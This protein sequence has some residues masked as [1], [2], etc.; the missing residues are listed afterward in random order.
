M[1]WPL[2]AAAFLALL[3][4][5]IHGIVGDRIVRRIQEDSLPGNPFD[6]IPTKVLIRVTWHFVTIAFFVLGIALATSGVAPRGQHARGVAYVAGAAFACWAAFALIYAFT[7]GGVRVFR[8][9]PGPIAFVLTAAL[10]AWGA[11]DL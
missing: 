3:G 7:H 1:S 11:A 4:A 2:L 10:I 5:A 6:A 9:H 8:S